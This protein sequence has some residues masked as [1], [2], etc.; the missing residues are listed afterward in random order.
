MKLPAGKLGKINWADHVKSAEEYQG[1]ISDYCRVHGLSIHSLGYHK[2]KFRGKQGGFA[3]LKVV[4][5][6]IVS[7]LT[8][9]F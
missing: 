5:K 8:A 7:E 6:S 1:S 2:R 4:G 9:P 3:E